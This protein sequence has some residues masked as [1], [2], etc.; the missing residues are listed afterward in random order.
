MSWIRSGL[1]SI[2]ISDWLTAGPAVVPDACETLAEARDAMLEVLGAPGEKKHP[3]LALRIRKAPDLHS[4]WAMRPDL[5]TA[6]CKLY[7]E[8]DAR[9][10][11]S[12]VTTHFDGLL[13]AASGMR[14]R[15]TVGAGASR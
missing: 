6:A 3:T 15:K 4:L 10:K 5:M 11:L 7:G 2:S 9:R 8:A 1:H 13:P 12:H 14:R